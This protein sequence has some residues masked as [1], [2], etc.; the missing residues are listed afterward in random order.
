MSPNYFLHP[1]TEPLSNSTPAQQHSLQYLYYS[2]L[3]SGETAYLHAGEP[4]VVPTGVSDGQPILKL[5]HILHQKSTDTMEET[6][7]WLE[8]SVSLGKKLYFPF[9]YQF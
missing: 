6:S 4:D 7:S 8:S 1:R 9:A 2:N 5:P 3:N